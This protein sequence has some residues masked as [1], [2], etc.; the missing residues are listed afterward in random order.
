[1]ANNYI[2][3]ETGDEK[4]VVTSRQLKAYLNKYGYT[5]EDALHPLIVD[6]IDWRKELNN[7][8]S[9]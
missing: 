6:I 3:Y 1:M 2:L 7:K 9:V 5:I 4:I 8:K